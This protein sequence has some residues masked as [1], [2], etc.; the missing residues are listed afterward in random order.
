M[1]I[2]VDRPLQD[3]ELQLLVADAILHDQQNPGSSNPFQANWSVLIARVA[4]PPRGSNESDLRNKF[5]QVN[6]ELDFRLREYCWQL[7]GLGFLVPINSVEQ[8]RPTT[9]G[10]EFLETLDPT[11]LTAGALDRV[12][13]A[14]GYAAD[15]P[16]RQYARLAQDCL[17]AGHKESSVVMLGVA[18][19]A[20]VREL[21]EALSDGRQSLG[22]TMKELKRTSNARDNLRWLKECLDAH[23]SE[24]KR[25]LLAKGSNDRWVEP[26]AEVLDGTGQAIRQTRNDLGHPTGVTVSREQALQLLSLFPRFARYCVNLLAAVS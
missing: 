20:L 22:L 24:L 7:V 8:F 1:E 19:E 13:T 23:G 16:P 6:K 26:L 5:Y 25:G 21:A 11:A 9:R 2:P 3:E 12:M 4:W 14:F 10:M 15:D 17:L 18:A